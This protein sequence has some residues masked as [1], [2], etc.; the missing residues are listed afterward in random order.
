ML[1]DAILAWNVSERSKGCFFTYLKI[2]VL[3]TGQTKCVTRYINMMERRICW[4]NN[5]KGKGISFLEEDEEEEG[6][7][8][9]DYM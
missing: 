8:W 3:E 6:K 2:K 5:W 7:T 4:T 1:V 9:L